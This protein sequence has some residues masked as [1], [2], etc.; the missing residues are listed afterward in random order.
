MIHTPL[1][2]IT[3]TRPSF[4]RKTWRDMDAYR[5]GLN[6]REAAFAV[7]K[8]KSHRRVGTQCEICHELIRLQ[9]AL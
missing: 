9:G 7:K 4:F 2:K 8:Y 5:K 3:D 6:A 1:D